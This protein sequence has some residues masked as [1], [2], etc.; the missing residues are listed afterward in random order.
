MN[1]TTISFLST[2]FGVVAGGIVSIIIFQWQRIKKEQSYTKILINIL[3][4]RE[5][6]EFITEFN[7]IRKKYNQD[8]EKDCLNSILHLEFINLSIIN[9]L[10]DLRTSYEIGTGYIYE[11]Y[12]LRRIYSYFE[13]VKRMVEFSLTNKPQSSKAYKETFNS[14]N[15]LSEEIPKDID[16]LI[17]KLECF[18][19]KLPFL[20]AIKSFLPFYNILD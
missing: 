2:F 18:E 4:K 12:E 8:K 17:V 19:E 1:S 7:K 9:T 10:P 6:K 3:K 20:L 14:I 5:I 16:L 11:I 15:K 13:S